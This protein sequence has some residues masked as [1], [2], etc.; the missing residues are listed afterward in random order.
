MLF[1]GDCKQNMQACLNA[2]ADASD[3]K[4]DPTAINYASGLKRLGKT[5]SHGGLNRK[6]GSSRHVTGKRP[7]DTEDCLHFS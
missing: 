3:E 7:G 4:F 5:I 2:Q 6:D 1:D